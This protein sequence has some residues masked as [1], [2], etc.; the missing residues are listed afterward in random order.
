MWECVCVC[1]WG[2]GWVWSGIYLDDLFNI[3]NSDRKGMVYQ[4]YPNG[5]NSTKI[6][7][8]HDDFDLTQ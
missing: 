3:N 5:F 4:T 8:K 6:Y 1:M 2:R 7:D